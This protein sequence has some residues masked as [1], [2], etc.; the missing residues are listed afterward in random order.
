VLFLVGEPGRAHLRTALL[1]PDGT[2]GSAQRVFAADP[3]PVLLWFD[4]SPE[5]TLLVYQ[6]RQPNLTSDL[7]L[8]EFPAARSRWL[9]AAD[10]VQ[11]RFTSEGREIVYMAGSRSGARPTGS[12]AVIPLAT[13]PTVKLG[14]P[15]LLFGLDGST[16]VGPSTR[17]SSATGFDVTRDGR[18]FILARRT[19]AQA[20]RQVAIVQNW[21][22]V[23][24]AG[25]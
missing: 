1:Q 3:E 18:R 20:R 21:W 15:A 24:S 6:A 14:P 11:P 16:D 7:F 23:V 10:A 25:R 13:R 8:T 5:G 2:L 19:T 17:L 12:I 4:L 9:V 22:A